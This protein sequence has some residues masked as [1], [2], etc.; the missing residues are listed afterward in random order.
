[1][2]NFSHLLPIAI[3]ASIDA[4]NKI[5]S[6]YEGDHNVEFKDDKS[7]LTIADKLSNNTI[8]EF[9][10]LTKIPLLS[11]EG[12]Y[13]DYEERKNWEQFWLVDPIDGTKEFIKRNGEF[14][15]NIALIEKNE[16]V[17]GVIYA[18]AIDVLYFG[19]NGMGS[20]MLK[21]AS[22]FNYSESN[23]DIFFDKIITA[24]VSLPAIVDK[25]KYTIVASRSH[26]SP[27]TQILIDVLK[28][29]HGELNFISKGSSLK[30]CLVAEGVADCYPRLAPTMEWDTAAGHAIAENAGC[31]V[32]INPSGE[33][34]TYNKESLLNPHFVV[35]RL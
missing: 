12:R 13:I 21:H 16:P 28:N 34:V 11:E 22:G 33:K 29:K 10:R 32:T 25:Q 24:S 7:P 35:T 26:L 9:L 5:M 4:G 19:C 18:P 23:K 8:T 3:A 17:L 14:T 31:T 30:I 20:Y 27:E 15:V 2:S 1:M 6:V